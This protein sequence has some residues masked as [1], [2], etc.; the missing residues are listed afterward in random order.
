ME[1]KALREGLH[2]NVVQQR[3]SPP[4]RAILMPFPGKAHTC[5]GGVDSFLSV[6]SLL[7][8]CEGYRTY[9][10]VSFPHRD[11][12]KNYIFIPFSGSL[13]V[14]GIRILGLDSIF[15]GNDTSA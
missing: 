9:E 10:T 15:M 3:A 14:T 4:E 5:S 6:G 2:C 12:L 1:I 8:L 7:W 11:F 13:T